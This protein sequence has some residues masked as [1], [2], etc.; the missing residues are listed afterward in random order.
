[1]KYLTILAAILICGSAGR[2]TALSAEEAMQIISHQVDD[3][4]TRWSPDGLM[5]G[6]VS[7]KTGNFF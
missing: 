6:Y 7:G 1:M 4:H 3:Y 5:I 2:F